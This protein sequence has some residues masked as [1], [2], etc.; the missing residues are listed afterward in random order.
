MFPNSHIEVL[1]LNLLECKGRRKSCLGPQAN[2]VFIKRSDSD[3]DMKQRLCGKTE[4]GQPSQTTETQAL[5]GNSAVGEKILVMQATYSGVL[6]Y[7]D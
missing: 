5:R 7:T 2:V 4:Q 6:C 3:T 1:A